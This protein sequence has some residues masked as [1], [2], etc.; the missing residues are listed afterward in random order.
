MEAL[1]GEISQIAFALN[2]L[3]ADLH[4]KRRPTWDEVADHIAHQRFPSNGLKL[5][6]YLIAREVRRIVREQDPELWEQS[7]GEVILPGRPNTLVSFGRRYLHPDQR[8][9]YRVL[10][11]DPVEAAKHPLVATD[12][13]EGLVVTGSPSKLHVYVQLQEHNLPGGPTLIKDYLPRKIVPPTVE[14]H[15]KSVAMRALR[16]IGL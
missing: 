2:Q 4:F 3:A 10:F 14:D 1:R 6:G 13:F 15:R 16:R 7:S 5:N 9:I 12:Y 11:I 8:E